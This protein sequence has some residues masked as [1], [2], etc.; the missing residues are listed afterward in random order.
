MAAPDVDQA[1]FEVAHERL[2]LFG[3]ELLLDFQE[4]AHHF[5]LQLELKVA[6]LPD[7]GLHRR[8]LGQVFLLIAR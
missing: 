7:L 5:F 3:L 4:M 8:P 1:L 2:P 6:D